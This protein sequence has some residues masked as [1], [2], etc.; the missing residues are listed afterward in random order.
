VQLLCKGWNEEN[1]SSQLLIYF[2]EIL[3]SFVGENDPD[4]KIPAGGEGKI[5]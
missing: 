5:L 1:G 3:L 2:R 4:R